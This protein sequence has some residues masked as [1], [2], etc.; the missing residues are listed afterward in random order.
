MIGSIL[1]GLWHFVSS[2]TVAPVIVGG[3]LWVWHKLHGEKA[4]SWQ[5]IVSEVGTALANEAISTWAPGG[6]LADGMTY[7]RDYIERRIW[8]VLT[9]RN[10][11]RNAITEPIIHAVIEGATNEVTHLI[12]NKL[13]AAQLP[14]QV[15][16]LLAKVEAV[17]AAFN[18]DANSPMA[19]LGREIGAMV[20]RVPT[21]ETMPT[22]EAT[23]V[24][25]S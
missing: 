8:D 13:A 20:E 11:P 16:S 24:K 1:L 2:P 3:A 12:G 21:V 9:K 25:G 23:T 14:A 5:D 19:K 17:K 4:A 15:D 18:V 6:N 22:V 7:V 10:V